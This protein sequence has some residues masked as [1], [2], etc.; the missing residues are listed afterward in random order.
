MTNLRLTIEDG[1]FRD[2]YGRQVLLR[3]INVAG[4]AKYPS[5]P[6]QPSHVPEDFFDGDNVSFVGR[7][8]SKEEAHLHFSRLKRCGYNT[9]RYVFTWE[10][11]EAAGPG[12]YDE[13]WIDETIEV[14]RA[15]KSYGF[16]VFMDPHQDVW[17]RFSGGSGAPMWTLYAAGLNPQSFAATEA[18]I[19]HNTYPEP[20][21][22]PKMI[23]STNYYR[24]AAATMFTLFFAGRDFA[25]RCIIDGV[26][27]QDYLQGHFLRACAHLAQRIHEAGDIENDVVFGW[28]SLNEPNKGM[29]GYQDISV[30]PKEQALKKGTCPTIWQTMLTG[31]GRAVEVETWD[32]GGLGPYRV[33]RTLVDPH[34]EVAWLPEGYDESRYGY[35]RDPGWKLGECIWA[36]HGVWDPSTDTLLRKDYFAKHPATGETIDYSYFTNTYFMDFF[37]K[38]RDTVRSVHKNAI[39]LLQGPTMELPPLIKDTPDGDDPFLVYSPHW[40]DGITLMTKKWNRNWNVDVIGV[41]RGR[42]WHPALAV[43]LGE[44]AIRNC[45]RD[46]H[47]AMRK[48]GLDRMGNH[49]CLMTEFG[50][51]YDMD[52]KYAYK[53]GDY[54]SQ[55][56]AM[57]ANHFGVEAAGLEGYTL[58]L[59]MA[60]NDHEKGDQW[61]GEDLSI[62]SVDDKL[63]PL[64]AH[65]R[66]P[67]LEDSTSN[68]RTPAARKELD[69][70]ESV[71]PANLRR[72][73]TN[74]SISL[75]AT[76]RQ[77]EL[78]ASPGYRAAE[79][80]VRPAPVATAGVITDYGFDLRKCLFTLTIQAPR[81]A[82]PE[83]P[84]VVFL[85]EYHFPKDECSV[86][87]SSGKWEISS[88]EEETV[89]IQRLRW[90]HGD[91]QQTLRVSGVIK[92]HN[93]GESAEDTGYYEQ[94]NQG[95]W[96]SCTAM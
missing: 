69:D 90:W 6:N 86:E 43:K 2:G 77:P 62:V 44:T 70:D 67:S 23:W 54:S 4:E 94:C 42:Y 50:I 59:Y 66:I 33:G 21:A 58:W 89:L 74:P 10:A 37:R 92:K 36:Q 88:D 18:A 9:I 80:Y 93:I 73:I 34:G 35:K 51:P 5:K 72:S 46:Q 8:F 68:L 32:M 30:I 85:P 96:S 41:L 12:I 20:D 71:T 45:F 63:L 29:I 55:S 15:A 64:S 81:V 40:Y 52:D 14:L 11:I 49:P 26:N 39:I 48:E 24:L 60:S 17:S 79:A 83:A 91:G 16:Y 27:I 47:A 65:P 87:V 22:F 38:Y 76:S 82:D 95:A 61:N 53:T 7:P 31:S 28:E 13:A 84:T 75:E 56:A 78:T 57:D 1:K 3:G 19:V 25:P